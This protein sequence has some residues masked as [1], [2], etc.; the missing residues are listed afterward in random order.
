MGKIFSLDNPFF[1][2][3]GRVGD[4]ML[5]DLLWIIFSLPIVTIGASTT[6]MNYVML[7]M[8]RDE[9]G[10]IWPSFWKSFKLNFKQATGMWM[11][12]LFG[13]MIFGLDLYFFYNLDTEFGRV[14]LILFGIAALMYVCLLYTSFG[15]KLY[16]CC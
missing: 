3:M 11:I 1:R 14:M 13:G 12:L 2:F 16:G 8:V 10:Y 5:L 4:V 15:K 7:K 6:A 9:E